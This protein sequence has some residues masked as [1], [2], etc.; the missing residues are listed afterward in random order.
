[1][2]SLHMFKEGDVY[3]DY[4]FERM[5]FRYEK[6][7]QKV[8]VHFYGMKEVEI[9]HSDEHFNEAVSSGKVITKEQYHSDVAAP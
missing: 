2:G 6:A 5:K 3:L 7:T 4:A 1:M 9:D 8:F